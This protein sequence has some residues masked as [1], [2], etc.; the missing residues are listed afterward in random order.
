M[1]MDGLGEEPGQS[2]DKIE[3]EYYF[4]VSHASLSYVTSVPAGSSVTS[5]P[6]MTLF[7]GWHCVPVLTWILQIFS[8]IVNGIVR[9]WGCTFI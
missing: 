9:L 7:P 6:S 2:K 1:D 5:V 4:E 3:E 8:E